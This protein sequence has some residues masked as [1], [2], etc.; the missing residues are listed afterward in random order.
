MN[1]LKLLK[2]KIIESD[3]MMVAKKN[4]LYVLC[5]II[6][7][8]LGLRVFGGTMIFFYIIFFLIAFSPLGEIIFRYIE[9]VRKIETK[10]EKELLNPI[11][12][13][14]YN[15]AKRQ[16]PQLTNIKL[17]V[18]DKMTVNA[19]ALGKHTI[20][21]SKGAIDTFSEDELKAILT[22]EIAHIY[23]FDSFAKMYITLA[24]GYFTLLLIIMKCFK[25]IVDIVQ[26]LT[27]ASKG[28]KLFVRFIRFA[29][30]FIIIMIMFLG[31]LTVAIGSR[32]SEYRADQF[33]YNLG[34]GEELINALYML[35]KIQLSNNSTVVERMLASH[36]RV[37]SRI[38]KLEM[39]IESEESQ[40]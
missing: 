36:P 24:N 21:I 13:E 7:F 11:W 4:P 32:K 39:L 20:A 16:Y 35:E 17:C 34:L 23:Y 1:T 28:A 12:E 33:T 15:E 10:R 30:E 25:F 40:L 19:L 8:I 3:F 9:K 27:E 29:C 38:E 2:Y 6:Y 22:H 14:V 26:D 31:Q 5:S 18:I 37:S